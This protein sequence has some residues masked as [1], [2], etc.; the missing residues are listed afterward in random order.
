[1]AQPKPEIPKE[2]LSRWQRV[3]DLLAQIVEV[4]A[5]LIMKMEPP[6]HK[7]FITSATDGNPYPTDMAFEL[8]SGL[9]CDRVM[10]DRSLLVV[11]DALEDPEWSRNPD[12]EHGMV[13][14]MGLPLVWP[15]GSIFGTICVL[16]RED[17]AKARHFAGL[18]EAF[19]ATVDGDLRLLVELAERARA[20]AA[21]ERARDE[22]EERVKERTLELSRA[23]QELRHQ[24]VTRQ[25]SETALQEA[26]TALKV[27]LERVEEA[28]RETEERILWNIDEQIT[29]YLDKL[30]RANLSRRNRSYLDLLEAN[31]QD[32]ADQFPNRL[33]AL[34]TK[35]T[36]TELEVAKLVR[37]GKSTKEIADFLS[38]AQSTIDFHRNNIRR[39]VGISSSRINL[40]TYLSSL[41]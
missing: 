11:P 35:L 36:P 33:S 37:Q 8:N 27:L 23:N 20:E 12:L 29:P 31:L 38:T 34:Y 30:K 2:L 5:G 39:K 13:F 17:N 32:I 21:L 26:N 18:L 19:K 10:E 28:K 41:V 6:Q 25:R 24:I 40:R 15:D 3:V 9:Y 1:M 7:V 22:L 4:P 14:Y 16:D